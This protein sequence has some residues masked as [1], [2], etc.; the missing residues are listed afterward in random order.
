M[1]LI[2]VLALQEGS[3]AKLIYK[4][5]IN[6]QQKVYSHADAMQWAIDIASGAANCLQQ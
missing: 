3:M 4:Q 1:L 6:P 2:A 5:M